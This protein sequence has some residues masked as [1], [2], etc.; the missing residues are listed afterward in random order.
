[1]T[2]VFVCTTCRQPHLR[3][4]KQGDPCG[5]ALLAHVEAAAEGAAEVRVVPVACV[6]GCEHGCN[7]ALRADN[8]FGYVLG[9]FRPEAGDAAAIVEYAAKHAQSDTG[10][11]AYRAWPE[12]VKGHF[13][14]RIPPLPDD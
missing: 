5:E 1:M 9:R 6:M 13:I 2:T 8:K 4:A 3:E 14:A 11:V 12:G 10:V 7:V